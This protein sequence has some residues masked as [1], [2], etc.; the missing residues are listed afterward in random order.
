[1]YV[2]SI[3]GNRTGLK[4]IVQ[5]KA[6]KTRIVGLHDGMVKL[7]VAAPPVDGKANGEVIAFLADFFGLKKNEVKIVSGE[8]SRRKVCLLGDLGEDTIRKKLAPFL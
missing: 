1:V 2:V 3:K 8:H 7:A 6:S 4:I 5:P